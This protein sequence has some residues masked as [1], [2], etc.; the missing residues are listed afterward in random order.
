VP[1]AAPDVRRRRFRH[2]QPLRLQLPEPR[3]DGPP[4]TVAAHRAW[5]ALV[6]A[7]RWAIVFAAVVAWLIVVPLMAIGSSIVHGLR[8]LVSGGNRN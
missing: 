2:P 3:T 8:R 6:L 1:S 7:F 5:R 4:L